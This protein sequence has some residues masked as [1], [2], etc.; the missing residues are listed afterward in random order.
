MEIWFVI[1][2]DLSLRVNA[3]LRWWGHITKVFILPLV[4]SPVISVELLLPMLKLWRDTWVIVMTANL[5]TWA[6]ALI[7][8]NFHINILH[9]FSL[10][11]FCID[12]PDCEYRTNR[13]SNFNKHIKTVHN[14]VRHVC[15]QCDKCFTD[16]CSLSRHSQVWRLSIRINPTIKPESSYKS[17][18][19]ANQTVV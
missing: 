5:V 12:C 3:R 4:L 11:F 19:L 10:E 6:P 1:F 2:V 7:L 17:F 16:R 8:L 13:R 15:S 14:L 9:L 18:S